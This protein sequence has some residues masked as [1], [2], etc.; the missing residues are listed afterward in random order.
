M[1]LPRAKFGGGF[2]IGR[3]V[4]DAWF[5]DFRSGKGLRESVDEGQYSFNIGVPVSIGGSQMGSGAYQKRAS[6]GRRPP[7]RRPEGGRDRSWHVGAQ[8]SCA[9]WK[10]VRIFEGIVGVFQDAHFSKRLRIF[11]P[12]AHLRRKERAE[13]GRTSVAPHRPTQALLFLWFLTALLFC[14]ATFGHCLRRRRRSADYADDADFESNRRNL[15]NL[16][17]NPPVPT[18]RAQ[19][20]PTRLAKQKEP[21]LDLRSGHGSAYARFTACGCT[22]FLRSVALLSQIVAS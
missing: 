18:I 19:S 22:V 17:I 3:R 6:L 16:R 5:H 9:P 1:L 8:F 15:R 20:E 13:R 12:G 2:N 10:M 4:Y 14:S 7:G 21:C 11:E